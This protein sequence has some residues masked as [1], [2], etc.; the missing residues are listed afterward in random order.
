MLNAGLLIE[1]WKSLS[2]VQLFATRGLYS[3]WNSLGQNTG[4]GGLSHLQGIF[5][6]QGTIPGLPKGRQI[7]T[8][9]ATR[10]AQEYCSV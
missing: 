7:F 9:G 10:E 3:P 2:R 1:K 4:V 5:P 8:S 6:T